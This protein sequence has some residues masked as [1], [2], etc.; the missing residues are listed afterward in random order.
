MLQSSYNAEN[1]DEERGM[2]ELNRA[3][4]LS[5]R[6]GYMSVFLE[7][8]TCIQEL[9]LKLVTGRRAS[10]AVRSY[11]KEA[12]LLFKTR[13]EI[14]EGIALTQGDVQGYYALTE[15][16]REVLDKL[17]AGMS[18]G[19]IA[20]SFGISQNTVK[21]HLKNIYSKLGVHTRSEAYRASERD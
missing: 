11:A 16:E 20:A 6:H 1:G 14:D 18:R 21:S 10:Y 5:M 9:L 8:R 7:G 4:E 15:R 12:L 19:E 3:L 17:N 2:V 13:S